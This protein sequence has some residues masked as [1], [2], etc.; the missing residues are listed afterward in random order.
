MRK[1]ANMAAL[2]LLAASIAAGIPPQLAD[3]PRHQVETPPDSPAQEESPP[4]PSEPIDTARIVDSIRI[5]FRLADGVRVT[6]E[7][8]QWD[9]EGFDGSFGRRE[10]T[11]LDFEDVWRLHQ[12]VMD[13]D[14]AFDWVSLGRTMLLITLDQPK[15]RKRA[16]QSFRLALKR[17][18][19]AEAAIEAAR[20]EI[21][22]IGKVRAEAEAA[23]EAERLKTESPESLDWPVNPWPQLSPEKREA[24]VAE[25][26]ADADNALKR[27]GLALQPVET[28]RFI[29]FSDAPRS[30]TALWAFELDR[31]YAALTRRFNLP[32]EAEVFWGKAVIFVFTE[33]DRFVLVEAEAFRQLASPAVDGMCHPV[34]PKV[35]INFHR[36]PDDELLMD[37]LIRE[38]VHGFMHRYRSPK[39]LPAWAN[40]GIADYFASALAMNSHPDLDRRS[41]GLRFVRAGGNIGAAMDLNHADGTWPGPDGIGRSIGSMM[42][43]LMIREQPAGFVKWVNAIKAGKDWEKALR[44]D[45]G[46]TRERLIQTFVSYYQVND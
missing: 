45:F 24:A 34:G 31:V 30:D 3:P 32:E 38:T 13:K 44:Q 40:E 7:L 16:D 36:Q 5:R 29:V 28:D 8:T 43:E 41:L 6:G 18:S 11:E 12:R 42:I 26:R 39:R 10:W 22:A 2:T 23:V 46:A 21:A 33:R 1:P 15:A 14:S 25:M 35:F 9:S 17:D 19:D 37:G 27:A 4:K 20:A